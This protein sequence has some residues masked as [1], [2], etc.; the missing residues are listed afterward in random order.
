MLTP[1][2]DRR[3]AIC[4]MKRRG[5]AEKVRDFSFREFR[6]LLASAA[7]AINHIKSMGINVTTKSLSVAFLGGA[8]RLRANCPRR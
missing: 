2:R 8:S 4:P 7:Q 5:G 6:R 3:V 1:R